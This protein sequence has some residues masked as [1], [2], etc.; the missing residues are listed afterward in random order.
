M[1]VRKT[2]INTFKNTHLRNEVIA[3]LGNIVCFSNGCWLDLRDDN[4]MYWG[5]TPYGL[6]WGCNAN[7]NWI[8]SVLTWLEFWDAPR[9]ES[10]NL[11]K[12]DQ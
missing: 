9:D 5:T 10:G 6:D 12:L 1:G 8:T 7:E 11:V 4:G 3:S 2:N